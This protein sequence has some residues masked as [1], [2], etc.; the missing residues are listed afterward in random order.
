MWKTAYFCLLLRTFSLD[1][2]FR[3]LMAHEWLFRPVLVALCV[4]AHENLINLKLNQ[5]EW[6]SHSDTH[7]SCLKLDFSIRFIHRNSTRVVRFKTTLWTHWH[8]LDIT[9]KQNRLYGHSSEWINWIIRFGLIIQSANFLIG[10]NGMERPNANKTE[11]SKSR[12]DIRP[13]TLVDVLAGGQEK[14]WE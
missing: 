11:V 1:I 13:I 5:A 14:T 8:T 2:P 10:P 3:F 9:E 12:N 6:I 4:W 7:L